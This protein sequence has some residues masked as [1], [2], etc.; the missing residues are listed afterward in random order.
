ME[1]IKDLPFYVYLQWIG[2][3]FTHIDILR[4]V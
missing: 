2:D 1:D 4:R 3:I